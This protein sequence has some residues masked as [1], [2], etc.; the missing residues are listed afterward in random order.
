MCGQVP[1][2]DATPLS[3]VDLAMRFKR[4]ILGTAIRVYVSRAFFL[5]ICTCGR[6]LAAEIIGLETST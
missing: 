4:S 6:F 3:L 1:R 2:S 5:C